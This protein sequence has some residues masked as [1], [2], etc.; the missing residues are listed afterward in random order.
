MMKRL[1]FPFISLLL[2]TACT[3]NVIYD[4]YNH[5]AVSGWDRGEVLSFNTA[6]MKTTGR[7]HT[8]LGLRI[9]DTYPFQALTL[10]VEQTVYP[11]KHTV[12]D[13]VNCTLFDTSG[14]IMGQGISYYQYHYHVSE[15]TL[16]KGDSL[17]VTVRHDMQRD[18]LPGISDVGIEVSR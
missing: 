5:T 6:K 14:K 4:K 3:G 16:Q 17:H 9:N 18:I 7:Y 11:E 15:M 8:T 10:I 1:A 12:K 2:L 13:T